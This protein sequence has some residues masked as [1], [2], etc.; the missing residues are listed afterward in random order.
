MV[1]IAFS[2]REHLIHIYCK[3]MFTSFR[4]DSRTD[5]NVHLTDKHFNWSLAVCYRVCHTMT[6]TQNTCVV[7]VTK[8]ICRRLDCI[9]YSLRLGNCSNA[10]FTA[11]LL[12]DGRWTCHHAFRPLKWTTTIKLILFHSLLCDLFIFHSAKL[13]HRQIVS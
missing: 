13:L 5:I 3:L 4:L 1:F 10:S 6:P 8:E 12:V 9:Q 11:I 7:Y 2:Y